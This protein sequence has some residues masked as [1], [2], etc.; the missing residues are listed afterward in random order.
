M[1]GV[2]PGGMGGAGVGIKIDNIRG[3]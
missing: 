2:M 3:D 1:G